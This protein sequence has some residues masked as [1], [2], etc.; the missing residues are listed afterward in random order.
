MTDQPQASVLDVWPTEGPPGLN[1]W[2]KSVSNI[3]PDLR[4]RAIV[5][6]THRALVED[7]TRDLVSVL[8]E[9]TEEVARRGDLAEWSALN[10]I[11]G[12]KESAIDDSRDRITGQAVRRLRLSYVDLGRAMLRADEALR[13][14]ASYQRS[15]NGLAMEILRRARDVDPDDPILAERANYSSPVLQR[16]GSVADRLHIGSDLGTARARAIDLLRPVAHAMGPAPPG[17]GWT[18]P[19]DKSL[20][21]QSGTGEAS[22][23]NV[24]ARA[25]A[26]GADENIRLSDILGALPVRPTL[27]DGIRRYVKTKRSLPAQVRI[28]PAAAHLQ[29]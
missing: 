19:L 10:M 25:I 9:A 27:L 14:Q 8:C 23:P 21:N 15:I 20:R 17:E 26:I 24:F 11:A 29:A 7:T 22:E 13:R 3:E 4:V 28:A 5:D 12:K 18:E 1:H 6:R 2:N 16:I